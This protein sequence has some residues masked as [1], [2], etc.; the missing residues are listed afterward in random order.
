MD[1]G[2]DIDLMVFDD[3]SGLPDWLDDMNNV[4]ED[5]FSTGGVGSLGGDDPSPG[6]GFEWLFVT[7]NSD[8]S[9]DWETE[10]DGFWDLNGNGSQDAH[11]PSARRGAGGTTTNDWGN[12]YDTAVGV[13]GSF[14]PHPPTPFTGV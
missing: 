6:D 3:T 5:I 12:D 13:L 8:G 7:Q 1:L 4:L 2:W 11:E 14:T 9:F 10:V